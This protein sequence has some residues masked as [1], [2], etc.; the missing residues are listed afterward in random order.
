MV[1]LLMCRHY[2]SSE[3]KMVLLCL[4][5]YD[6]EKEDE[7][8]VARLKTLFVKV[9]SFAFPLPFWKESNH[10][11]FWSILP[12]FN[13]YSSPKFLLVKSLSVCEQIELCF[14]K[15]SIFSNVELFFVLIPETLICASLKIIWIWGKIINKLLRVFTFF[16]KLRVE[17]RGHQPWWTATRLH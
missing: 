8:K 16:N 17:G 2:H 14:L 11:S 13:Q 12:I 10:N 4:C 3:R 6:V 1:P 7:P 15:S 9:W 5:K